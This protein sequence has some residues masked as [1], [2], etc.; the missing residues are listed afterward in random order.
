MQ[1]DRVYPVVLSSLTSEEL[2]LF[3]YTHF[4]S[5][6]DSSQ[7]GKL[8]VDQSKKVKLQ[9]H[10]KTELHFQG[11][12]ENSKP[13]DY[14]LIFDSEHERFRLCPLAGR[15]SD[16][17]PAVTTESE[18]ARRPKVAPQPARTN[19]GDHKKRQVKRPKT[20]SNSSSVSRHAP[21]NDAQHANSQ[22]PHTPS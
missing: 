4:P 1:H 16:L 2:F 9:L 20:S 7:L 19:L 13:D 14:I 18:K 15:V 10:G 6:V 12:S 8:E 3:R 11:V 5:S 21:K 22:T 17:R